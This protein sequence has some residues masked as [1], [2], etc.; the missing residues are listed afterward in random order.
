MRWIDL[1]YIKVQAK[2]D[3]MEALENTDLFRNIS[4]EEID[5]MLVCAKAIRRRLLTGEYI[6]RQ[7]ERPSRLYLLIEG[8]V[9]I[10]KHFSSGKR[11]VLTYVEEGDVFGEMFLFGDSKAYW[12]DAIATKKSEILELPWEFLFHFCEKVCRH[13]QQI[14]QNMLE[15]QSKKNFIM[16]RKLH[17]LSS[18]TLREKIG[19]WLMDTMD[20][21]NKVSLK[22]NREELADYLGVARP[23]LSRELMN[24]QDDGFIRVSKNE[25][26]ILNK[27]FIKGLY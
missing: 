21:H 17:I 6:F 12:Y 24:L 14:T 3:I 2:K 20:E 5:R 9:I 19:T 1:I 8:N 15:I 10:S 11:D 23:S 18:G 26:E 27:E 22:L 25:I 13:H 16:A 7:D 4:S